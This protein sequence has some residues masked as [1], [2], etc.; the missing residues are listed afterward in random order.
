MARSVKRLANLV[1]LGFLAVTLGLVY[2]Q[3]VAAEQLTDDPQ[4]NVYRL[5]VRAREDQRGRILDRNG[6]PLA[7]S[8]KTQRGFER[9]YPYPGAA[10]ITGYW[11]LRFG[12]TG[13]EGLLD[14]ALRGQRGAGID[15]IVSRALH[16]PVV[17]ADVVTTIDLRLQQ[18]TDAALGNARGAAIAIDPR[19]G[20]VLALAS[21][22]FFDPNSVDQQWERLRANE[23]A[24]LFNRA[25]QGLYAPGSTFKVVTF[26]AALAGGVVKP[27]TI[28]E[29]PDEGITVERFRIPDPNHPGLPRFDAM[30]A[31]ALSSNSAF[32]EMGL[33]LG[34]QALREQALR[35]GFEQPVPF[36]L[37]TERSRVSTD[38]AFLLSQLGAAT[39]AIGQGQLLASP[40]QMAAVAS[41]IANKGT[42]MRPRLVSEV[43]TPE[44]GVL[45]RSQPEVLSRPTSPEV[46]KIV[47][48]AM[49]L[50]VRDSAARSAGLPNAQVAG[51]TGTAEIDQGRRT[52]AWF[53]GFAPAEN[54]RV[55]VV[56][57]EEQA[58]GG[59]TVAGPVARR[60]L[61]VGLQV[62]P[63]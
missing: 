27:D 32:A 53:I 12:S 14:P 19:S 42:L 47:A 39:T 29:D 44:G 46:A 48:D 57:I 24:P 30:R 23:T 55:A 20:E 15:A 17:G 49:V 31:L 25:T 51:K 7:Y 63:Q 21:H 16:Q 28:F 11:S 9:R 41:T 1:L 33:R 37:P 38:G 34:G 45:T 10:P 58:G 54:P 50:S 2:W 61:E 6:Q 52:H 36:D 60:M 43:R 5:T 22:P 59:A 62:V 26:T 35:F 18:A 3:V 40:I 56:V 4:L 8:E 13:V